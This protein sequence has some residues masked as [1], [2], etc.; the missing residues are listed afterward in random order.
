MLDT[1]FLVRKMVYFYPLEENCVEPIENTLLSK[2]FNKICSIFCLPLPNYAINDC[3]LK[4]KVVI[5]TDSSFNYSLYKK[6]KKDPN[7][8]LILY[9]LNNICDSN[10]ELINLFDS[11]YTFDKNDSKLYKIKYMHTPYTDKIKIES[12]KFK[13]DTLFL[14]RVKDRAD[15]ILNLKNNLDELGLKNKFLVLGA[16]MKSL[17]IN[18]FLPYF[19][20]IHLISESKCIVELN[21]KNQHGCSLRFMEALFFQKK[22]ITNNVHITDDPYY[23]KKNM[24]IINHD[25]RNLEEFINKPYSSN[26]KNLDE[27]I[28]SNWL[29]NFI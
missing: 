8:K 18:S 10:K 13:Y 15:E 6:L 16:D 26:D 4:S 19:E 1:V 20:Y 7:K 11:V 25:D 3:V 12:A 27:L 29:K 24:Y 14:G 22:L 21:Q 17:K 2:I 23:D 9:Y 5:F 28:F